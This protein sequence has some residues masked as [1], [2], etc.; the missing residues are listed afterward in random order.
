M[1]WVATGTAVASGVMG[2]LGSKKASKRAKA[3]RER[4]DAFRAQQQQFAQDQFNW[5]KEIYGDHKE[6]FDPLFDE[7]R[8]SMDDVQPDYAAISGDINSSFDS[9]RGMESRNERRYGIKPTDGAARQSQR[10]YGIKRG[11]AHV[12]ARSAARSGAKQMKYARRADLYNSGQGIGSQNASAV[13]NAMANQQN[14]AASGA[15]AAGASARYNDQ[16]GTANAAGW[17]QAIGSVDWGGIFNQVKG[18]GQT[19]TT[20]GTGRGA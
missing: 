9:A 2:I 4:E 6:K 1:A 13:G 3:D 20:G 16:Q 5:S 18:W 7:M 14:A 17:G 19:P 10:E 15:N 8:E 12:G 11:A